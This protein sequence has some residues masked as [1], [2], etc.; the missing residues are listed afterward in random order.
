MKQEKSKI[1]L[2][3]VM[4]SQLPKPESILPVASET[5]KH[6]KCRTEVLQLVPVWVNTLPWSAGGVFM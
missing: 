6:K 5:H 4:D 3:V 2:T 1:F